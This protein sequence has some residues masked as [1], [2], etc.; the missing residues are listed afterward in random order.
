MKK[1]INNGPKKLFILFALLA[2]TFVFNKDY[3]KA[4]D[5]SITAVTIQSGEET[6]SSGNTYSGKIATAADGYSK[7]SVI[8]VTT[9][10]SGLLSFDY[11]GNNSDT[12]YFTLYADEALTDDLG[13]SSL[14][15]S[16]ESTFTDTIPAPKAGTYYLQLQY[17]GSSD[18]DYTITPYVVS[19][20]DGS[21]ANEELRYVA[22]ADYEDSNYYKI[23][24]KKAGV[25]KVYVSYSD[26]E[27]CY[28]DVDICKKTDGKMKVISEGD[29]S[30]EGT[31][32]G[33]PKGT[34]Y[35]K[36]SNGTAA[37]YSIGYQYS[38][39][40]EKSGSS[41]AKAGTIK[42]G[43]AVKGLILYSDKTSKADWY[44]IKT[45]K[46]KEVTVSITGE[47]TGGVTLDFIGSDGDS[48]GKLYI[49][50][51]SQ[52][53]SGSPYVGKIYDTGGTLPKGTY[54]IKV[55]KDKS[56]VSGYYSIL[57]E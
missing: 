32:T 8:A 21:L 51:Y 31:V 48:F 28:A 55:T 13:I 46:K 9:D 19:A 10:C 6:P 50:E 43:T 29:A 56:N 40:T 14:E 33:L 41:K 15:A 36:L 20:D 38:G 12:V 42:L 23:V 37:Y 7:D 47:V 16:T 26:N 4:A 49:S 39:I 53:D 1:I 17:Y 2:V 30:S 22:L 11:Q 5:A 18:V 35:I 3:V 44:K 25:I 34:Y 57:V 24:L 45:T 54:Y 27:S 52:E